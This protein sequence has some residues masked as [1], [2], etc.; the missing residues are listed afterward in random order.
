MESKEIKGRYRGSLWWND[1][2]ILED[3]YVRLVYC[4]WKSSPTATKERKEEESED[5]Q[6]RSSIFNAK[7]L[8]GDDALPQKMKSV[9]Y[10]R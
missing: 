5:T 3:A 2:R 1:G 9:V 10:A 4:S 6:N 7:H 8:K